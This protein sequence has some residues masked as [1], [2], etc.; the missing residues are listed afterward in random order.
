V[1]LSRNKLCERK[2]TEIDVS[3]DHISRKAQALERV[4]KVMRLK[5]ARRLD[6]IVTVASTPDSELI[7]KSTIG[8]YRSNKVPPAC[9]PRS[10]VSVAKW[11]RSHDHS[12]IPEFTFTWLPQLHNGLLQSMLE[13]ILEDIKDQNI[14]LM[15][16]QVKTERIKWVSTKTET[17]QFLHRSES[18]GRISSKRR[19]YDRKSLWTKSYSQYVQ[20][21]HCPSSQNNYT[22][23]PKIKRRSKQAF[24]KKV[25]SETDFV[26]TEQSDQEFTEIDAVLMESKAICS[27]IIILTKAREVLLYE[28]E[29]RP[30]DSNTYTLV[31][32]P[33]IDDFSEEYNEKKSAISYSSSNYPE[34]YY[35][36]TAANFRQ[37]CNIRNRLCEEKLRYCW[38]KEQAKLELETLEE[39]EKEIKRIEKANIQ[40]RRSII[41]TE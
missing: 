36:Q 31:S 27:K 21:P 2:L 11:S 32:F 17:K 40:F 3:L 6:S 39:K 23:Q 1:L 34:K 9:K 4:L 8:H 24:A 38:K 29:R 10:E 16:T 22:D 19:M 35:M 13:G 37:L 14:E 5:F 30:K 18:L 26:S 25:P 28:I 20:E 15:R 7:V 12:H 33:S 41:K